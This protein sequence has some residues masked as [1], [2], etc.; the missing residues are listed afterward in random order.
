M[1]L[2]HHNDDSAADDVA[3]LEA[4]VI[5]DL[6]RLR[7]LQQAKGVTVLQLSRILGAYQGRK[8]E[9]R[10]RIAVWVKDPHKLESVTYLKIQELLREDDERRK[11]PPPGPPGPSSQS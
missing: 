10:D 11:H 5:A 4:V 3:R 7:A 1:A 8:P 6:K 9:G 2:D